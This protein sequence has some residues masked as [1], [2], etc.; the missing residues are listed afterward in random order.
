MGLT[1]WTSAE[2][3][4]TEGDS[5]LNGISGF[6]HVF[7]LACDMGVPHLQPAG[8]PQPFRISGN[9]TYND[10]F[11]GAGHGWSHAAVGVSTKIGTGEQVC[12]SSGTWETLLNRI[13]N[14]PVSAKAD[15]R[16]EA[17]AR[18]RSWICSVGRSPARMTAST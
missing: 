9:V 15:A 18:R 8:E 7:G 17:G 4:P 5:L 12:L 1:S 6:I 16:I 11:G 13:G 10:G 3:W 14:L 2:L